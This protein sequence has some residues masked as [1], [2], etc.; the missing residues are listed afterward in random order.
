M[1]FS[2]CSGVLVSGVSWRF[3]ERS[4]YDLGVLGLELFGILCITGCAWIPSR[5]TRL[6][7]RERASLATSSGTCAGGGPARLSRGLLPL[8]LRFR[9]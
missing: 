5:Q 7:A 8:G 9:V 1:L 4:Y 6:P 3:Q 2:H